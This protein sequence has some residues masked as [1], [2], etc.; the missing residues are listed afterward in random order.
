MTKKNLTYENITWKNAAL[1]FVPAWVFFKYCYEK[2][3]EKKNK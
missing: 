3:N 1:F 2:K